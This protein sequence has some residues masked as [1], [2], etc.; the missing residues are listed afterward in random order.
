MRTLHFDQGL[1]AVIRATTRT[2]TLTPLGYAD[3]DSM[4]S[5]ASAALIAARVEHDSVRFSHLHAMV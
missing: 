4:I 3:P 1:S 5:A 2:S